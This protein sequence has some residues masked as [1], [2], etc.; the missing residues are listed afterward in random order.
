MNRQS[1]GAKIAGIAFKVVAGVV[2]LFLLADTVIDYAGQWRSRQTGSFSDIA[3]VSLGPAEGIQIT[4]LNP[5]C[6]DVDKKHIRLESEAAG[7]A[8]ALLQSL[9]LSTHWPQP[10]RVDSIVQLA[11]ESVSQGRKLYVQITGEHTLLIDDGQGSTAYDVIN[12]VSLAP[13]IERYGE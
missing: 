5:D 1:K 3:G 13:L 12:G 2:L 10:R 6:P 4:V 7:Q 11:I 8:V 9:E